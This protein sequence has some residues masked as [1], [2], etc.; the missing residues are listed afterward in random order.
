MREERVT[1]NKHGRIPPTVSRIAATLLAGAI[2]SVACSN[3]RWQLVHTDNLSDGVPIL[4]IYLFDKTQGFAVTPGQ[5][6]K[7]SAADPDWIPVLSTAESE[8]TFESLAFSEFRTGVIVGTKRERGTFGPL[9]LR[10]DDAGKTWDEKPLTIEPVRDPH[11]PHALHSVSFCDTRVVWAVGDGLIVKSIDQGASWEI[12]RLGNQSE[13]LFSI[14]C[15]G[16]DRAWAVGPNGLILATNDGGKNWVTQNLDKTYSLVRVRMFGP[17]G[18]I[19]GADAGRALLLRSTDGGA[20]WRRQPLQVV[21]TLMDLYMDQL[22]GWIVG[23]NG[24]ILHTINGGASWEQYSTPTK[25]DLGCLFF[26]SS[27]EGWAGG[28]KRTLLHFQN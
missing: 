18:W 16:A 5:L 10:T 21:E 6:L 25:N 13:R 22:E 26:L 23:S 7:F 19:V 2:I 14:S 8:R 15:T 17:D 20:T 4:A 12:Q 3:S 11:L 28:A 9:V 24:L 27:K 1:K